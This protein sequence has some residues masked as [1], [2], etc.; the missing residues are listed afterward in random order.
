MTRIVSR[1]SRRTHLTS[2][3]PAPVH[4]QYLV[5]GGRDVVA[6]TRDQSNA[7]V[8]MFMQLPSGNYNINVCF[9]FLSGTLDA[10]GMDAHADK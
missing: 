1:V 8:K 10:K 7:F 2:L 6:L 5:M 4:S 3:L 9:L